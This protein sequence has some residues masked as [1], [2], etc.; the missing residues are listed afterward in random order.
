MEVL[1]KQPK[2]A[3]DSVDLKQFFSNFRFKCDSGYAKR[4]VDSEFGEGSQYKDKD[5]RNLLTGFLIY[6]HS[7]QGY[8]R[9]FF[10]A[11]D[12]FIKLNSESLFERD[13]LGNS[14]LHYL[15]IY[16]ASI[17]GTVEEVENRVVDVLKKID[18]K[19]CDEANS[20]GLTQVLLAELLGLNKI[21]QTIK[22][23]NKA[24]L[25]TNNKKRI[26]ELDQLKA[27]ILA[28][29]LSFVVEKS[30]SESEAYTFVL[31]EALK[32]NS[33]H[34]PTS[35][36]GYCMM[37]ITSEVKKTLLEAFHRNAIF[38]K[39]MN[40]TEHKRKH[41]ISQYIRA[42]DKI[43]IIEEAVSFGDQDLLIVLSENIDKGDLFKPLY[44]AVCCDSESAVDYLLKLGADPN[45]L[46]SYWKRTP[47]AAASTRN[48]LEIVTRLLQDS[49]IDVN[50]SEDADHS[51]IALAI[52]HSNVAVVRAILNAGAKLGKIPSISMA[53]RSDNPDAYNIVEE[54]LSRKEDPNY[55]SKRNSEKTF[56]LQEAARKTGDDS[57]RLIELLF[58]NGAKP[59]LRSC[60]QGPL[61]SAL[62]RGHITTIEALLQR[63]VDPNWYS[64]VEFSPLLYLEGQLISHKKKMEKWGK[65]LS[66]TEYL[67]NLQ[68][69]KVLLEKYGAEINKPNQSGEL[70]IHKLAQSK[71]DVTYDMMEALLKSYVNIDLHDQDGKTPLYYAG[72]ALQVAKFIAL[73]NKGASLDLA[74]KS[75]LDVTALSKQGQRA[76]IHYLA[77]EKYFDE[78]L[79]MK[80]DEKDLDLN[81]QTGTGKTILHYAVINNVS[82][83]M[84]DKLIEAG[85]KLSL[86]END[87]RNGLGRFPIQ[88]ALRAKNWRI[89]RHLYT[90]MLADPEA[91]KLLEKDKNLKEDIEERAK[92]N[93]IKE[94]MKKAQEDAKGK[95]KKRKADDDDVDDKEKVVKKAKVVQKGKK[96]TGKKK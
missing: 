1:H 83:D 81:I 14:F 3:Q 33:K 12:F 90:K 76:L 69:I 89:F 28:K 15:I 79:E 66:D 52:Q 56:P 7:Y 71:K 35:V 39:R 42:T 38:E 57:V 75:G 58:A 47:L 63:G 87:S 94:F 17:V 61:Y 29:G 53:I 49:R 51:P 37:S 20:F 68:Q 78:I 50:K 41:C 44:C 2:L 30:W 32:P 73:I 36:L 65:Y 80:K 54:L 88:I 43:G 40:E 82:D 84:V 46:D 72:I 13:N 86:K 95:G 9:N 18:L 48:H 11:L 74:K 22:D 60:S 23:D 85:C 27:Q 77:E 10:D 5:D 55:I 34:I 62:I 24:A 19:D 6:S 70:P 4:E 21:A 16:T 93:K 26:K 91:A 59:D 25:Y 67:S 31:V 92:D 64:S 45:G 96:A 8:W